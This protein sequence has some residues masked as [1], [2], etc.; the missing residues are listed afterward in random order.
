[1]SGAMEWY[2][3][4]TYSGFEQKVKD[5]MSKRIADAALEDK[6]A[7]ILIPT[8]EIAEIREG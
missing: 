4:N 1:M 5:H 6:V 7:Q 2:V 8:E 3:V